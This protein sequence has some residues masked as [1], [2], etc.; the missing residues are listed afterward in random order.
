MDKVHAHM[1]FHCL[2]SLTAGL[3]DNFMYFT[4]FFLK[5]VVEQNLN[6]T[7]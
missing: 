1:L 6:S 3:D 7:T 4:A 2:W 5:Q